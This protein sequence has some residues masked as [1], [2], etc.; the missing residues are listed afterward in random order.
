VKASFVADS[1]WK[2]YIDYFINILISIYLTK[3]AIGHAMRIMDELY[4]G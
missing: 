4:S 3:T 2:K 1:K